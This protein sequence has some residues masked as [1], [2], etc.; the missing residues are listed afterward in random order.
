MTP[1]K[2]VADGNKTA[3]IGFAHFKKKFSLSY[4]AML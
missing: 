4:I 3:G 2:C 1:W